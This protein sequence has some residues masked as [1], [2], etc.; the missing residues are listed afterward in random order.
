MTKKKEAPVEDRV[1]DAAARL[2]KQQGFDGTTVRQIAKAAGVLPGSLH[3]RYP[4]KEALLL[5]LMRRGVEMDMAE[6]RAAIAGTRDPVER[7]RLAL[8]ARMRFLLSRDSAS[9]VLFDWRSLKG[10]ARGEMIRL[11]DAYEAFWIGLINEAAGAGRLRPDIDLKMLRLLFFG[12]VNW[13]A[14]WY[15]PRGERR[16]EEIADAFWGFIAYGVFDDAGRPADITGA[17]RALSALEPWG[18]GVEA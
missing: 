14:L 9:V 15:S 12:A 6:V 17:L 10:A 16:P 5:A 1:V 18:R 8:R 3:Y 11:R 4:T 2:F 7:L 13:V